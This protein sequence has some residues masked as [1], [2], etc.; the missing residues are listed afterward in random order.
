MRANV[1]YHR[2]WGDFY[3][4]FLISMG[5]RIGACLISCAQK[6]PPVL[7]LI[8][9]FSLMDASLVPA[10]NYAEKSRELD[11]KAAELYRAGKYSEALPY[12]RQNLEITEKAIGW[13]NRSLNV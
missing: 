12:A 13:Q 7:T 1:K 4:L 3:F 8:I 2:G 6:F 10:Q 11:R 9:S 5:S